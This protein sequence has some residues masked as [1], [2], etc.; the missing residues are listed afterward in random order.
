MLLDNIENYLI[1]QLS[2]HSLQYKYFH[3]QEVKS[4]RIQYWIIIKTQIIFNAVNFLNS[5]LL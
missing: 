5:K 3:C 1:L 2:K 4:L